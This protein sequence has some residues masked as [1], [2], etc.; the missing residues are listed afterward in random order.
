MAAGALWLA[1][2]LLLG[3]AELAVPGVF[4]I[5]LAAAA[6]VTGATALAWPGVPLAV[7]LGSF[8]AWSAVAV[9]VGRHFYAEPRDGEADPLLSNRA[10]RLVGE[11]V[12]V[13]EPLADGR[14][15]VRVGDSLWLA[16]GARLDTGERARVV[17]VDGAVLVVETA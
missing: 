1:A 4:L 17:A 16:R 7:Q 15:R 11:V 14:G 9:A 13:T 6:A 5:F 12:T 10:A 8:A 3:V 2:A